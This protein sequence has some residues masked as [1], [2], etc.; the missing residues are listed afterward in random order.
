[1]K[2]FKG[3]APDRA[4]GGEA[5]GGQSLCPGLEEQPVF[6]AAV[7]HL[8]FVGRLLDLACL[9]RETGSSQRQQT[10]PHFQVGDPRWSL[11][12]IWERHHSES[13]E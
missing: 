11:P 13:S 5:E 4:G 2:R 6:L 9:P 3:I 1:M 7:T 10:H 8:S 12:A